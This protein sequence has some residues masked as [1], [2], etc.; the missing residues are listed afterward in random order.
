MLL[1]VSDDDGLKSSEETGAAD[2]KTKRLFVTGEA[3]HILFVHFS[4][5]VYSCI[6]SISLFRS[7]SI[8]TVPN[9]CVHCMAGLSFYTSEKT[10]RA[11]FEP[12][13]ELVEGL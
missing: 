11:A 3:Q 1:I 5:F 6:I 12:F 10:L 7:F 8:L 9:F 13:G 2:I 4:S